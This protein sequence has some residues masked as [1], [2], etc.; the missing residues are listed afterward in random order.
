[1]VKSKR[2]PV[3]AGFDD[4]ISRVQSAAVPVEVKVGDL[5]PLPGQPRRTFDAAALEDLAHSIRR[6]GVLQPL[7]TRRTASGTYEIVAGERR[8]R[9]A[10]L[11][12]LSTVPV[13]VRTLTDREAL[14]VAITENL[15]RADLNPVDRVDATVR[16]IALELDLEPTEVSARL[17]A[18][19]KRPDDAGH[20]DDIAR[21]E[22]LFRHVGGTWTTFLSHHLPILRFP[23]EV[24]H[25]MRT[26]GL[27][28]TKGRVI[29]RVTDEALRARLL[30]MARGGASL[31]ELSREAAPARV[32]GSE[33]TARIQRVRSA[34]ARPR[35]IEALPARQQQQVDRLLRQ[36]D[37]LLTGAA[38]EA[39]AAV[40][41]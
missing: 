31:E 18:L 36:L 41:D 7:V 25:A 28:Y 32:A 40:T 26:E 12:G 35:A 17:N 20:T 24:L 15:Q 37:D 19:R 38:M 1:M 3:S 2:P 16:L 11:A 39:P 8:W 34:L 21:L 33:R 27:E 10:V 14:E 13:T 23:P 6:S 22:A 4:T 5:T 29:A 30:A 9:A